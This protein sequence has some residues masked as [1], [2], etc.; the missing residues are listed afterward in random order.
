MTFVMLQN[1]LYD[2]FY[3]IQV[4]YIITFTLYYCKQGLLR[5]YKMQYL[6]KNYNITKCILYVCYLF[7]YVI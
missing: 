1:K 7:L 3:I 6:L 4:T 5:N 2:I